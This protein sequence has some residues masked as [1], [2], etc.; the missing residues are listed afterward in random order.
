MAAKG[1]CP[2]CGFRGSLDEHHIIAQ[3]RVSKLK[4]GDHGFDLNLI[5]N[6]GNI[7]HICRDCHKLTTSYMV[8]EFLDKEEAKKSKAKKT[9]SKPKKKVSK[10]KPKDREV[11]CAKCNRIGHESKDCY[12]KTKVAGQ[13][14]LDKMLRDGLPKR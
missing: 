11:I 13:S 2:I 14:I 10:S 7:I 6:P 1:T 9:K 8:R 12:S 5:T 3:G 4:P